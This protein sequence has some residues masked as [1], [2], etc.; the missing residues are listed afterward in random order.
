MSGKL[1]HIDADGRARMVDVSGKS[2]TKRIAVAAG[3][4]G[5]VQ[6]CQTRPALADV[7]RALESG[8]TRS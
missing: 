4:T 1:T 7:V 3:Q 2:S 8:W 5:F 6:I